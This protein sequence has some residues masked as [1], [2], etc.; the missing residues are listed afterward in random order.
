MRSELPNMTVKFTV[1]TLSSTF[2]L[3]DP[4]HKGDKNVQIKKIKG[5]THKDIAIFPTIYNH[6]FYIQIVTLQS[7]WTVQ[8]HIREPLF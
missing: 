2:I 1:E 4:M 5:Y 6:N 8:K 7:C 3:L